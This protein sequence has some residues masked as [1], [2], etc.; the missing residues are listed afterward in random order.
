M[1]L[2]LEDVDESVGLSHDTGIAMS[3][4]TADVKSFESA[5][6]VHVGGALHARLERR[7]VRRICGAR[8]A[9]IA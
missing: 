7:K 8:M 5:G 2:A 1:I 9:T 6:S 4:P 3:R